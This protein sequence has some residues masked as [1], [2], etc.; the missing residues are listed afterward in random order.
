MFEFL[1]TE[2]YVASLIFNITKSL[3]SN[4]F[5]NLVRSLMLLYLRV[6]MKEI[7]NNPPCVIIS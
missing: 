1:G 7:I 4:Q 5:V 6:K 3:P 2:Q